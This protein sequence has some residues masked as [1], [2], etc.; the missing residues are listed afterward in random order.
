MTKKILEEAIC[1]L[2]TVWVVFEIKV[3][4]HFFSLNF[5]NGLSWHWPFISI[6]LHY[7]TCQYIK[8]HWIT[9][10]R[11]RSSTMFLMPHGDESNVVCVVGEKLN[12]NFWKFGVFILLIKNFH[13]FYPQYYICFN[14]LLGNSIFFSFPFKLHFHRK[15]SN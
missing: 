5:P 6:T 2:I 9:L 10:Q 8:S 11:F 13:L 4:L 1:F 3:V 15:E 14:S 7:I 12:M